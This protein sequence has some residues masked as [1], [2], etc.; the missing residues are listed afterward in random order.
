MFYLT[1]FLIVAR[2]FLAYLEEQS[3]EDVEA[4][5]EYIQAQSMP[6]SVCILIWLASATKYEDQ[7]LQYLSELSDEEGLEAYRRFFEHT[8]REE[9]LREAA[10][11]KRDQRRYK[12]Y[13]PE[14]LAPFSPKKASKWGRHKRSRSRDSYLHKVQKERRVEKGEVKEDVVDVGSEGEESLTDTEIRFKEQEWH[15]N[16]EKNAYKI[17]DITGKIATTRS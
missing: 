13:E 1:P 11:N 15:S 10:D 2:L 17:R 5:R 7:L 4:Y 3:Q 16:R 9:A 6:L 12:A 8:Q 14:L